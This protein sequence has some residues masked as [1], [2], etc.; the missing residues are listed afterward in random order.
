MILV[1]DD[2]ASAVYVANKERS[3]GEVGMASRTLRMPADSTRGTSPDRLGVNGQVVHRIPFK[4]TAS[5]RVALPELRVQYF[6]PDTGKL[7]VVT[8]QAE[9]RLALGFAW[10]SVIAVAMAG[11]LLLA[12]RALYRRAWRLARRRR[13]RQL[14][15]AQIACAPDVHAMRAALRL[16]ADAEDW[17]HNLSLSGWARRWRDRYRSGEEFDRSMACLT[18]ACYGRGAPDLDTLRTAL[19]TCLSGTRGR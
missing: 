2:P 3:A 11:L 15:L 7:M 9:S 17:P 18:R 14:A 10:R 1:G 13:I 8:H 5:G 16:F 4:P 19:L 12:G 6:D